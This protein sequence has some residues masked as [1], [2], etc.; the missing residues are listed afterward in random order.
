M[1]TI[2]KLVFILF[3]TLPATLISQFNFTEGC[4]QAYNLVFDLQF[5]KAQSI[6][7][8]EEQ[9]QATNLMIPVIENYMDFLAVFISEDE[10]LYNQMQSE[11]QHRLNRI[12]LAPDNDPMKRLTLAG[13]QLQWAIVK[14]KFGQQVGAAWDFRRAFLLVSENNRL[15]PDHLPNR[16]AMGVLYSLV[17]SIPPNFQWI[18]RLASMRGTVDEGS[19]MLRQA[20][21]ECGSSTSWKPLQAEILFYLTYIEMNLRPDKSHAQSLLRLFSPSEELPYLLLYAKSNLL[22]HL[23]RND[24]ALNLLNSRDNSKVRIPFAFLDYM[25]GECHLRKLEPVEAA[26]YYSRFL[27]QYRGKNYRA[28]AIRKLA[29]SKL[30]QGDSRSYRDEISRISEAEIGQFD[31]DKQ[32][33]R[34]WQ[35]RR[36]PDKELLKARL[37][38]D[39]GYYALA[40]D[41]LL[42]LG[43]PEQM[44]VNRRV[45]YYYRFG[46]IRHEQLNIGE[47]IMFYD[48]TIDEGR[49]LPDFYAANASLKLGEIYESVG[50]KQQSE[51]YYSLCLKIMPEEYRTSIHLKAKAGLNRLR[52]VK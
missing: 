21:K 14:L 23:G 33:H 13:I 28:D 10:T 38:F 15:F 4:Q 7:K 48:K 36:V 11:K 30:I 5:D 24:E 2:R 22:M 12:A 37:L 9:I 34:E 40:A 29:W 19:L 20:L 47:A 32:A 17:G 18:V 31:S 8:K 42:T 16:I 52:A 25:T 46:R 26:I 51:K 39:G 44:D 35:S 27:Q 49:N 50:K 1:K 41:H 6:L 45:E 43:R 3:A